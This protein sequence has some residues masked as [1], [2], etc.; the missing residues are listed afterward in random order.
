MGFKGKK[1]K[2]LKVAALLHDI[3]KISIPRE[4]LNKP[5]K[6]T[7][8][9][10]EIVKKHTILSDNIIKSFEELAHLRPFIKFHHEKIDGSGY[11]F[12]L[13]GEDIPIQSRIISIAD[14][15]EALTGDRPYREPLPPS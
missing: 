10:F 5:G 14:I 8:E 2:D 13:K 3:G 12:G 11:P 4:I 7:P 6:L 15:F 9:E 1:L